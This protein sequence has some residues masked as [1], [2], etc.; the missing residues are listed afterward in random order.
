M[1]VELLDPASAP[2][3]LCNGRRVV[4]PCPECNAGFFEPGGKIWPMPPDVGCEHCGY[5][6]YLPVLSTEER[7]KLIEKAEQQLKGFDG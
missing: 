2:C 7:S 3:G 4:T 1:G 6:G 5:E